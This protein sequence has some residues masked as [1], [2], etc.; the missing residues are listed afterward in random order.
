MYMLCYV[1]KI[2][3]YLTTLEQIRKNRLK[4]KKRNRNTEIYIFLQ[5]ISPF[6]KTPIKISLI[7]R[8]SIQRDFLVYTTSFNYRFVFTYDITVFSFLF[9]F[10]IFLIWKPLTENVVNPCIFDWLS[11]AWTKAYSWPSSPLLFD[12]PTAYES[13]WLARLIPKY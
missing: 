13:P 3:K 7:F 4:S 2:Y 11:T 12:H 8:N 1:Y 10:C 9:N 6:F 5:K